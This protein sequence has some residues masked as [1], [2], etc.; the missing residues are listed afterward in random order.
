MNEEQQMVSPQS[1]I[2]HLWSARGAMTLAAAIELN[3]FTHI[4]GGKH[5]AKD[6]ARAAKASPRA[7]RYLLDALTGMGYLNKKGERYDNAPIA[8]QY[9]VKGRNPYF[10]GMVDETRMTLPGWAGL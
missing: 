6:V 4:D 3:V 10:G 8:A 9:L 2:D 1:I 5:T 7:M